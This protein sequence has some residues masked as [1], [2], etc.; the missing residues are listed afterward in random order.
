MCFSRYDEPKSDQSAATN[1]LLRVLDSS[2]CWVVCALFFCRNQPHDPHGHGQDKAGDADD[3]A[4]SGALQGRAPNAVEDRQG[5]RLPADLPL[6]H[7]EAGIRGADDRDPGVLPRARL[8]RFRRRRF[9][10]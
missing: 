1:S 9:F 4:G 10:P 6:P 7:P 5:R 2:V 8:Q 3:S